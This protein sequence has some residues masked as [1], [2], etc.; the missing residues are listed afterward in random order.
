MQSYCFSGELVCG[1]S[2]LRLA[3]VKSKLE[4]FV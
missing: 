1:F 2:Q 4:F 3:L